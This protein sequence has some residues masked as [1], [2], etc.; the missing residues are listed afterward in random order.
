M[1]FF[2]I[3]FHN[4]LLVPNAAFEIDNT[5]KPPVTSGATDSNGMIYFGHDKPAKNTAG[6]F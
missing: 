1:K 5:D 3:A 2:A 4:L 6:I